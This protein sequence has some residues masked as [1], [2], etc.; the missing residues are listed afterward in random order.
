MS[1]RDQLNA[2]TTGSSLPMS[3]PQQVVEQVTGQSLF[4]AEVRVFQYYEDPVGQLWAFPPLYRPKKTG[5]YQVW[6]IMADEGNSTIWS[7]YGQVAG[8]MQDAPHKVSTNL[9][10]KTLHEQ[11]VQAASKR[12]KDTLDDG[13]APLGAPVKHIPEAMLAYKL[14]DHPIRRWP[15]FVQVKVDGIRNLASIEYGFPF[16][17]KMSSRTR[18]PF[19]RVDHIREELKNFFTFLPPN[20]IIDGE[21]YIHGLSLNKISSAVTTKS[22]TKKNQEIYNLN[23]QLKYSIFDIIEPSDAVMEDRYKILVSAFRRYLENGYTA[24]TFYLIPCQLAFNM[25]QVDQMH[26]EAKYL[27]YE[28]LMIRA[29]AGTCLAEVKEQRYLDPTTGNEIVTYDCL[30][31]NRTA[32]TIDE[33]KYQPRRSNRLLKY[34]DFEDEEG[35]IMGAQEATGNQAGAIL[36]V[37]RDPRGNVL[38]VTPQQ[39]LADRRELMRQWRENPS[40]FIGK[41]Y[42]YVYTRI[43]EYGIAQYAR[44]RYIRWD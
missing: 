31:G 3:E 11:I 29:I 43:S 20:T 40:Q 12:Y 33:S 23:S 15:V 17:V 5:K 27:G 6:Q 44:G 42:N 24:N 10:G 1:L 13:Y 37:V 32:T 26:E 14:Q 9:S 16:N 21:F 2:Y 39:T 18:K 41:R 19:S 7:R 34:K 35:I 22:L 8:L 28:G 25:Q 30:L 36:F 4:P 38:T